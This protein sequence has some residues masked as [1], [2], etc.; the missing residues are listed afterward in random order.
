[1]S[2]E[3]H[4]ACFAVRIDFRILKSKKKR[5]QQ[6]NGAFSITKNG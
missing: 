4:L 5:R 1:M 2:V 3:L 6:Y